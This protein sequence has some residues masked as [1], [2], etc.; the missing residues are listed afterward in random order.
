VVTEL[1]I[2]VSAPDASAVEA[3]RELWELF[4]SLP[5]EHEAEPRAAPN[6]CISGDSF[7]CVAFSSLWRT[8][9]AVA[10]ARQIDESGEFFAMP[11]L[12]DALQ[13]AGCDRT[14]ILDH[15]RGPGPH[16]CC[17]WVV[18]WVLGKE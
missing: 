4:P 10:L 6:P 18:D 13:D 1:V 15:C 12:A 11:I 14:E 9:T 16:V 8:D 2:D 3:D 5:D 7:R 17:C